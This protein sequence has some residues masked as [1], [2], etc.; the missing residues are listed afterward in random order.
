M[1]REIRNG[2]ND[3]VILN[4]STV[5]VVKVHGKLSQELI[6]I[7]VDKLKLIAF[8]HVK[9]IENRKAWFTPVGIFMTLL[10]TFS[11]SE[12]KDF[13]LPSNVW[14]A[15]FIILGVMSFFWGVI[16][17]IQSYRSISIE[18]FVE[19]IKKQDI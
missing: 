13:I 19:K 18:D 5:D 3:G 12:F 9:E 16:S 1:G 17:A 8:T 14:N 4:T 7:T 6:Q 15:I 10:I 2:N 11:T